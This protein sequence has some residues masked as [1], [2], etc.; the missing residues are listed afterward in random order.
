MTELSQVILRDYQV[1]KTKKQKNFFITLMKEHFPSLRAEEPRGLFHTRNLILGNPENARVVLS[2]H[3]D[4]CALLP[5]PN[6]LTPLNLPFYLLYQLLLVAVYCLLIWGVQ[7]WVAAMAGEALGLAAALILFFWAFW[8]LLFGPANRH[9]AND[10][11]SGVITLMECYAAMSEEQRQNVCLVFFDLEEAGLIGSSNFRR[12]HKEAMKDKLLLN[13]D[14]VSDGDTFLLVSSH[15]ARERYGEALTASFLPKEGALHPPCL[16]LPGALPLR[17][18]TLSRLRCAG[19]FS[20]RPG[21]GD[22]YGAHPHPAG[23]RFRGGEYRLSEGRR[24]RPAGAALTFYQA[25]WFFLF[26]SPHLF[27][28]YIS[29]QRGEPARFR[30][31]R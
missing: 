15:P 5:F 8:L 23:H 21:A 9:T 19:E 29:R 7:H 18:G 24:A 20:H 12:T 6:F 10:N 11:T 17:S 27:S 3:Y 22:V 25:Q 28:Y 30:E 26:P 14:C 4:T 16:F 1:R 31:L 13:F 2:A